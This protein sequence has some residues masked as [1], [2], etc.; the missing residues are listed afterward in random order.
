MLFFIEDSHPTQS[1]SEI[2][3][4]PDKLSHQDQLVTEI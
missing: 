2:K 3:K 4:L 1:K